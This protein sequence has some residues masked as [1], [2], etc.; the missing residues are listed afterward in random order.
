MGLATR[1]LAVDQD[2]RQSF[3]IQII[4]TVKMNKL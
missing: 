4:S 1:I 3:S 2:A